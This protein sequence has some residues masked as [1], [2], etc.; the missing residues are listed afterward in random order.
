MTSSLTYICCGLLSPLLHFERQTLTATSS[1]RINLRAQGLSV[2]SS[3]LLSLSTC[4]HA[5]QGVLSAYLQL[6]RPVLAMLAKQ[7]NAQDVQIDKLSTP[8]AASLAVTWRQVRRIMLSAFMVIFAYWHG[9]L[10]HDEAS[11]YVAMARLLL[12]YPRWRWGE[13]LDEAIQTLFDISSFANFCTY[14]HMQTLLP[15]QSE[16]FLRSLCTRTPMAMPNSS[17]A[18]HMGTI[19]GDNAFFGLAFWPT[20]E[21]Y[22]WNDEFPI[23]DISTI[24]GQNVL[25]LD[26]ALGYNDT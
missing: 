8:N 3:W 19:T 18:A 25:S 4:I 17:D 21:A 7:F 13:A 6:Y 16:D 15:G 11:R 23:F 1:C 10:L 5:A 26:A 14:E 9:E 22:P 12:E 2:Q 20:V 24:E